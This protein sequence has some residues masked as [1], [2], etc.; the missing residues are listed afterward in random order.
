MNFFNN[1]KHDYD[2][3]NFCY[4]PF[5]SLELSPDGTCQVCCKISKPIMNDNNIPFNLTKDKL[6][7]IWNS[8]DLKKLRKAFIDGKKPSECNLCWIEESSQN[9]SLRQHSYD[10]K[11]TQVDQTN[12][13]YLVLKLSN[14][15]NLKCRICS[16]DLSSLWM[17][18]AISGGWASTVYTDEQIEVLAS[19]KIKDVDFE[20][21]KEWLPKIKRILIYGGEPLL[22]KEALKILDYAVR[23]K[24]C[25]HISITLNTN[26]TVL[27][28]KIID[29]LLQFQ[30]VNYC[31]SIDDIGERLEYQRS[32]LKWE[33]VEKNLHFIDD[34]K[35]SNLNRSFYT[36]VSIFNIFTIGEYLQ[37]TRGFNNFK[38]SVANTLHLPLHYNISYMPLMM[39]DKAK[40]YLDTI[41][42]SGVNFQDNEKDG[43]VIEVLKNFINL[44]PPNVDS[45]N[46]PRILEEIRR[47]DS[48]RNQ[49][50]STSLP[51]V[52][53]Y[54][55]LASLNG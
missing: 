24:D 17:K 11:P 25:E 52:Y 37:W 41:N 20:T 38:V 9:I 34:L 1:E 19:N 39:K 10:N 48:V 12:L 22:N 35:A 14:L 42:L 28:Q 40:K 55:Q 49:N 8:N 36:T 33:Q 23:S 43:R 30:F 44:T 54:L 45:M 6:E 29:L 27:S 26:G 7:D 21:I 13:E 53:K 47:V 18:E 32:P 2:K 51:L 16:P 5:N 50:L 3:N 31:V 4:M 46:A 15:C